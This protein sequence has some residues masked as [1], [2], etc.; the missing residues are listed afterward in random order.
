MFYFYFSHLK[1]FHFLSY[2]SAMSGSFFCAHCL[3]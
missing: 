1:V 2:H 3:T